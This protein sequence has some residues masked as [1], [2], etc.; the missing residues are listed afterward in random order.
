MHLSRRP[1]PTSLLLNQPDTIVDASM[2]RTYV[3]PRIDA[4]AAAGVVG[5]GFG[6]EGTLRPLPGERDRN[7]LLE[8]ADGS[9]YVVKFTSPDESDE[10]LAFETRLLSWLSTRMPSR[11]PGI[12]QASDGSSIFRHR[13]AEGTT[14][15]VRMLEYLEGV[16]LAS[17]R[18]KSARLLRDVGR[19]TARLGLTLSDFDEPSPQRENFVWALAEIGPVLE[20]GLGLHR[21]AERRQLVEACL[22]DLTRVEASTAALDSQLVHGD[23]NDHNLL[24]SAE[25][26]AVEV[27]G[28]LDLGDA[29]QAPAVFDLAVAAAYSVLDQTDP[30]LA[31]AE[32]VR[33]YHSVRPLAEEELEALFP[34]IRAR[35]AVSVTVSAFRRGPG[36]ELDDYLLVSEAPAWAFLE[37]TH[38]IPANLARGFLRQA[39]GRTACPRSEALV[40]AIRSI[41]D[42]A[43]VM[44]LPDPPG[45]MVLDLSVGSQDR[46]LR[47]STFGDAGATHRA[48]GHRHLRPAGSRGAC[49]HRRHGAP[50]AGERGPA[51]LRTHGDPPA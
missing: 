27:T 36:D 12:L 20:R 30:L 2:I 33:G 45:T 14:W 35:L 29:H 42:V 19:S 1:P 17:T 13:T 23:L 15:R 49:A 41:D 3:R 46:H 26:P 18:P 24:V 8:A 51:R 9:R 37:G 4:D 31:A 25:A 39:C 6:L 16:P 21:D 28:I 47:G 5:A 10:H 34:L 11:V 40:A 38:T 44:E 48:H 43:P 32:V 7:F 22:E 50:S